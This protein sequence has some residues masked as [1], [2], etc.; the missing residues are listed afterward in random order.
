MLSVIVVACDKGIQ[1][2]SQAVNGGVECGIILVGEDDVEVSVQLGGCKLVEVPGDEGKAD[3]VALG[4]MAENVLLYLSGQVHEMKLALRRGG[5]QCVGRSHDGRR[6]GTLVDGAVDGGAN[7]GRAVK[8]ECEGL[9][10][11]TLDDERGGRKNEIC[12]V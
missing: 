5:F 12:S 1:A 4:A 7:R 11:S 9:A 6:C 2:T 3:Q 10:K 8:G